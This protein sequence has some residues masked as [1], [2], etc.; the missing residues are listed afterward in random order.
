MYNPKAVVRHSHNYSFKEQLQRY[1]DIGVFF[2]DEEWLT[3]AFGKPTNKA[4]KL[5]LNGFYFLLPYKL[6]WIPQYTLLLI[7]KFIGLKLGKIHKIL[8]LRIKLYLTMNP[9]YWK[10]FS[11]Y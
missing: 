6:L 5:A 9:S 4:V 1:F 11:Q 7:A 8:P 10:R 2:C 3:Q